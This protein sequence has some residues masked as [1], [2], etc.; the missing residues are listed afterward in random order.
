MEDKRR[1]RKNRDP[2]EINTGQIVTYS[3]CGKTCLSRIVSSFISVPA[4]DEDF[5]IPV[6]SFAK[7]SHNDWE[8]NIKGFDIAQ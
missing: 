6:S 7:Q 5:L 1:K 8:V 4:P 2:S 3:R